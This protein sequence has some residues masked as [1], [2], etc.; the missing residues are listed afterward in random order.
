[1]IAAVLAQ[2]V[3][4]TGVGLAMLGIGIAFLA[5]SRKGDAL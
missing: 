5:K 1:M 3:A 2:Q 4:F